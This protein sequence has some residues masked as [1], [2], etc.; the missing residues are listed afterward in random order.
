VTE[1]PNVGDHGLAVVLLA[2]AV[3]LAVQVEEPA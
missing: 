2:G 1:S 3:R